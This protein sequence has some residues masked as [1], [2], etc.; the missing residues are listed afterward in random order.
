MPVDGPLFLVGLPRSGTTVVAVFLNRRSSYFIPEETHLFTRNSLGLVE[1]RGRIRREVRA[2]DVAKS[3]LRRRIGATV[4]MDWDG[5]LAG[6][7]EEALPWEEAVRRI[8]AAAARAADKPRWGEKT[9]GHLEYVPLL[10]ARFPEARFL[11]LWRGLL[12]NVA[13]LLEVD[14]TVGG[15]EVQALRWCFYLRRAA[16]FRA[17]LPGRWFDVRYES[18]VRNPEG[19]LAATGIE[20]SSASLERGIEGATNFDTAAEPWK[21][22]ATQ[23]LDASRIG[24]WRERLGPRELRAVHGVVAEAEAE[25]SDTPP[26][27]R[28]RR[29]CLA[30]LACLREYAS[31]WRRARWVDRHGPEAGG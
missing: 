12:D 20:L 11:F 6:F 15:A 14:W 9:P 8:L 17:M 31:L 2:A 21:A 23:P 4:A 13:S 28:L 26:S 18:F 22:R 29:T 27:P 19:A 7:G 24:S 16:T 10:A 1:G 5:L 25:G 30:R 3:E